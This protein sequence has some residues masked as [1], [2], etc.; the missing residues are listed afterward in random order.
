MEA[1]IVLVSLVRNNA[2]DTV[3]KAIGFLE[4]PSRVNVMLSRAR[5]LLVIAGSLAH[6]ERHGHTLFWE[7]I[8]RYVRADQRFVFNVADSGFS[9]RR[10]PR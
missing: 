8:C 3:E 2:S 5:R 7:R 6:F 1:E 9:Y 10:G 4:D